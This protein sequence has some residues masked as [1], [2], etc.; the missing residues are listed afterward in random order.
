MEKQKN[1]NYIVFA[2]TLK[3]WWIPLHQYWFYCVNENCSVNLALTHMC[4]SFALTLVCKPL[5]FT[6]VCKSLAPMHVFK[7]L[8]KWFIYVCFHWTDDDRNVTRCTLLTELLCAALY[9]D[10]SFTFSVIR[11]S[12][13][14]KSVSCAFS[15]ISYRKCIFRWVD[16]HV[17]FVNWIFFIIN[18]VRD[19][20]SNN[21][22]M[23]PHQR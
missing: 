15:Q 20:I 12:R 22:R 9:R 8:R 3:Y 11:L 17:H 18:L 4:K 6:H 5:V 7:F 19:E 2:L 1:T 21:E 14:W 13:D 10:T 16:S 23:V